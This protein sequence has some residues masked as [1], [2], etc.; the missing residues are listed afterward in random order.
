LEAAEMR[1][2][3]KR[4]AA[5]SNRPKTKLGLP[6]LDH[7]ETAVLSSLRS[8]ESKR[9]YRHAI[10]EFIEWYCSEP[11]LSFNEAVVTRY[12]IH[13]EDRHLA[14]G[15]INGRL[16]AVRRL[17]YEAADSGLL[18]PELAAGI[19]RVKGAKKLRVRFGN[20]LTAEEARRLSQSPDHDSLKGNRDHAILAV[21]LG[22]GLR[23]C[24]LAELGFPHQ[25]RREEHWAIVDLIG[26][27]GHI[28]TVP[29]PDWVKAAIDRWVAAAGISTGRLF[30]CVC[31]AGKHWG[32]GI[33]EKVVWHVVKDYAAKLGLPNLAPHDLRRSCAKLCHAAGG[34]LEQIQF[35]LGHVSVQTTE[36]Y[37]G[38]KQRISG[39]VNDRIGI[40]P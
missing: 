28:R 12:R 17:A 23:R 6:D 37:L 24:E 32:D 39:A 2:E 8:P 29:V 7:S 33:T 34:E 38:C 11:R 9:G 5:I 3:Q 36:R 21:L 14:P 27:G 22:C 16:A 18:S 1:R 25:Q 13:L 31:R 35:L 10:D 30:R 40:E 4:K 15:T 19:R 20:W 26:K